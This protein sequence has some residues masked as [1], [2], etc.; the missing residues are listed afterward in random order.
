MCT[1]TYLIKRLYIVLGFFVSSVH[2]RE[3]EVKAVD[4][5]TEMESMGWRK[6]VVLVWGG[7]SYC[8]TATRTSNWPLLQ[9]HLQG[10]TGRVPG[11][12]SVADPLH[13]SLNPLTLS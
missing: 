6:V 4:K 3:T 10:I 8:I 9:M 5:R 13:A 1:Y 11:P 7:A 12:P 2:E